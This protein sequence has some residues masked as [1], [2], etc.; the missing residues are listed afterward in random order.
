VR[1][2]LGRV[3]R[4][5]GAIEV[6]SNQRVVTL[7]GPILASEVDKVL[8][9]ITHVRDVRRVDNQLEVHESAQDVPALQGNP[10]PREPKFELR[11]ENWS[12]TARLLTGLGGGVLSIY[13]MSR[14]GLIGTSL[15][16][17]G[18]GL[19]ARGVTNIELKRL[20][21]LGG[22]RRAI[23][24]QKAININAP[25]E[26]VYE[27]WSHFENFPRFMAH[28][29]EI[30]DL[31][32]G[33]SHWKVAGPAGIP[34]EW[35]AVITKQV[36]NQ[37]IAWKSLPDEPVKSAGIVQ[38]HPNPDGSTRVTVRLSYNPPAGAL[39][40]TVASLFGVE[41]KHAMDEDLVRLKSLLETGK[42]TVE[43]RE[44]TRQMLSGAAGTAG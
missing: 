37:V 10:P 17:L 18:L 6:S 28:V 33:R 30:R 20:L 4:H 23:D 25:V 32:S 43:G 3:S 13:G 34:V 31:G 1:A 21:G 36:P 29:Q 26:E 2:E 16:L 12:P 8:S 38:F 9:H 7:S 35:E 27:I 44:V 19:A 41:P 22:G 14:R 39:G 40:H 11:Q 42:T 15:S 24:V 5:P